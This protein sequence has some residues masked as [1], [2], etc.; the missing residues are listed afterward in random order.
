MDANT[1]IQLVSDQQQSQ[2]IPK[3]HQS[4]NVINQCVQNNIVNYLNSMAGISQ[5]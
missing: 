1:Y 3:N 2:N 5:Y 4:L